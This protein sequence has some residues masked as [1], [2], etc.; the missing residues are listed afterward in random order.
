MLPSPSNTLLPP[1]SQI[2]APCLELAFVAVV[3]PRV[4]LLVYCLAFG[5]DFEIRR[6]GESSVAIPIREERREWGFMEGGDCPVGFK[7]KKGW[8]MG[9]D[10]SGGCWEQKGQGKLRA[11]S[12]AEE[13]SGVLEGGQLI[14][15]LSKHLLHSHCVRKQW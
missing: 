13:S 9:R 1:S 7:G 11:C 15:S 2:A 4:Y 6:D 10:G 8:V 5:S 12:R 3:G 14:H